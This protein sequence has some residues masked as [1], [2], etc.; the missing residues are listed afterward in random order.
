MKLLGVE[1]R[2]QYWDLGITPCGGAGRNKDG[3]KRCRAPAQ[4]P[5]TGEAGHRGRDA[6]KLLVVVSSHTRRHHRFGC[7][8]HK[9]PQRLDTKVAGSFANRGCPWGN[10][11]FAATLRST[12]PGWPRG[13]PAWPA[14]TAARLCVTTR[15]RNRV[16]MSSLG[17]RMSRMY[18]AAVPS[19]SQLMSRDG[20]HGERVANNLCW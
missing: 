10:R 4:D 12:G 14:G 19:I 5:S 20:G 18:R 16:V 3:G 1:R 11:R 6:T 7:N 8:A 17:G 9:K 2:G 15:A 13:V